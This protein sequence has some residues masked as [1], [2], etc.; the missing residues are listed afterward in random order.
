MEQ[1]YILLIALPSEVPWTDWEIP[2]AGIGA[3]LAGTGSL[4]TGIAALRASQ[5]RGSKD[6]TEKTDSRDSSSDKS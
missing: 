5:R 4:L 2:W 1:L 3:L 6:E